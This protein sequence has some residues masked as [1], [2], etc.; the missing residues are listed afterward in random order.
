M[1]VDDFWT[2]TPLWQFFFFLE[3]LYY[4]LPCTTDRCELGRLLFKTLLCATATTPSVK[5]SVFQRYLL[6]RPPLPRPRSTRLGLV[7]A[8]SPSTTHIVWG[9]DLART[10]VVQLVLPS[11]PWNTT[12]VFDSLQ[13]YVEIADAVLDSAGLAL[14][15]CA[16]PNTK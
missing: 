13:N 10:Q 14:S 1:P 15:I 4:E 8:P 11:Q 9:K 16:R 7:T 6:N 3:A 5:P 12:A 2:R